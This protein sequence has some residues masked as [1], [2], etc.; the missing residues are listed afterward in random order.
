[1]SYTVEIGCP[2]GVTRPD[3]HFQNLCKKLNLN[4]LKFTLI[5]TCFGD[6]EWEV[7][8]DYENEYQ[9]KQAKVEEYLKE[10]YK[11]GHIRYASW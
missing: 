10:L 2:P 1:M 9:S 8:N 11:I 3:V 6:W 7:N 5:S 4:P